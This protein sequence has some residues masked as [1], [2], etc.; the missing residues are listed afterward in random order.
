MPER[1]RMNDLSPVR[2]RAEASINGRI[3]PQMRE[4]I[5]LRVI[6]GISG[7]DAARRAGLA[8]SGFWKAMKRQHVQAYEERLKL[9]YVQRVMARREIVK[10]RAIEVAEDLMLNAQSEAVRMR[11][12]EFFAGE[13]RGP[14]V[15]VQVN[16][17]ASAYN[18]RRPTDC[19]SGANA[20]QVIDVTPQSPDVGT[21]G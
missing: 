19:A 20:G 9:E 14:V 18:Y 21:E 7:D 10:A 6:E 5:R 8:P 2:K 13:A 16:N 12:V 1:A 3:S 15:Q 11:A 4:A 17:P